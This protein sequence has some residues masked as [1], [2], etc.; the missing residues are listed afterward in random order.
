MH[1]RSTTHGS[2]LRV[3]CRGRGVSRLVLLGPI[4]CR[5]RR[6]GFAIPVP[7][8]RTLQAAVAVFAVQL[9]R[10]GNKRDV[11]REVGTDTTTRSGITSFL[12]PTNTHSAAATPQVR[13]NIVSV[14]AG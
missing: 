14:T 7:P 5:R 10:R 4:V 11:R 2:D 12:P 9:D 3:I 8:A 6:F 13:V 1:R